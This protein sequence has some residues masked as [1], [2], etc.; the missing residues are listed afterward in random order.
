MNIRTFV[1]LIQLGICVVIILH[2]LLYTKSLDLSDTPQT[3]VTPVKIINKAI[4][5]SSPKRAPIVFK[6]NKNYRV[7]FTFDDGPH[8][9]HT[10]L[11]VK[12]L[13]LHRVSAGFF[14]LGTSI[15]SFLSA[16][17]NLSVHQYERPRIGYLLLQD[18]SLIEDLFVQHDIYLHGWLH[19]KINEMRLQ[20]V[21]DNIS[22]QLIEIGLLKG[23]KPVYRAPWGIGT[24]P[25]TI[26]N[27]A[28]LSQILDQIGLIPAHWTIDSK[29][30][31]IQVDEYNLTN[32]I[33]KMICR[34]KGGLILMHDN[35]PTTANF[36]DVIIRS[37]RAS[38]HSIVRPSE[39]NRQW[40]NETLINRTRRYTEFLRHRIETIQSSPAKRQANTLFRPVEISL[41]TG[42]RQNNILQ[43]IDANARYKGII[44]VLPNINDFELNANNTKLLIKT[45]SKLK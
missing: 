13:N 19:E 42:K 24:A 22:T 33:L 14:L 45:A 10:P 36:L 21:V 43:S 23:F 41:P 6:C 2:I 16:R 34:T 30:Y 9:T 18:Y 5:E 11:V 38:G 37:I 31:L 1:R 35:R 29:D 44:K 17:N 8:P 39:I 40:N 32:N 12:T 7:A 26:N 27:K 4:I 25:G 3:S 20:T 28:I 15:Q